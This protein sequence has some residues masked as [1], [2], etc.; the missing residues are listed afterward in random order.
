[1]PLSR[2]PRRWSVRLVLCTAPALAAAL[3]FFWLYLA[4]LAPRA[5]AHTA[6]QPSEPVGGGDGQ[7]IFTY[8][9]GLAANGVTALLR[10][11][12]SLWIGTTAGLSRYVL[13]GRGAGLTWQTFTSDDEMAADAVN[14]LWTDDVGGLWVAHPDGPI[15]LFDGTTWTTYASPTQTLEQAYE[16]IIATNAT[17]PLWAIEQ[18]GRVWTL[19]G[20]TVGY[21]VGAVWRPYGEDAGIPPGQLVAVWTGD[22]TWVASDNGQI[23]YFG[24][25]NWTTF[26]NAFD[27]VQR[28]YET[29]VASDP[30]VGPLWLVDREGGVWVRNAFNQRNP[31]PDVRRFAGGGWTS[32]S[33]GDGMA[34]GFVAE[35]RLDQYGRVWARHL[36]DETGQGGGLSLY[37][38]EGWTA[39]IPAL[40]GNVTDFWPEG[41]D[42]V[43]IGGF[44]QPEGG[45]V[46]VGGL[47]YVNL[48]TWQRF[49]LA[50]LEGAA[51]SDNWLDENDDLWLG[52][53]SAPLAPGGGGLLRYRPPQGTQPGAW[54]QVEGSLGDDVRDLWGDGQG[55]LWAAAADG[56][57][58]IALEGRKLFSYTLPVAPDQIS[59]D[60]E[61][62]VWAVA[63]G[64]GGG[65]WQWDGSAWAS[66]TVGEGLSGG[67][68]AD[69]LVSTD[70]RVYLA[71]DRGLD[72][73]D[74][75]VREP[76]SNDEW[77][78]FATLPGRH[79]RQVWQDSTGDLWLS[80]EVTPG[81]PFMLSLNQ[82]R[83]WETVLDETGSRGMGPEPLALLR[84]SQGRAWLGAP[85]GL[86]MYEPDGG[87]QWR[88]LGPVEGLPAGLVPA[89]YEDAGGT[90][91]VAV[92]DQVYR[93]DHLRLDWD[94]RRFE[95]QV[96]VVSQIAA[97]PDGSVLFVGDAGVALYRPILPDLRLDGVVN[98]ITGEVADGREPVVL[99]VGRSAMRVDLIV[100]AP[101]LSARQ[102]SYRYRLEGFDDDW[103]VLP[104]DAL[105]GKQAS[106]AY[107]GLP[108]GV[109]TFTVAARTNALDYS[110]DVGFALYVLSRP[111]E[112]SLDG[113]TIA[114]RPA[115][116][117][118]TL[119]PY[120]D[121]PIQIQLSGG[122]DQLEPLI[123]RYRIEG[124][125]DG[126]TE[127]T[128]PL[129][130]FT[131]SAADTYTFVA[132]ALD[133]E[134]QS[135]PLVGSQ[136]TVSEREE[137]ER[138][139]PLPVGS[140]AAG[141]G[142]TS[143]LLIGMA[144]W[145][146]IKRRRRESW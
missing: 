84:D 33:S 2:L 8:Q 142:V 102:L 106:I 91:W 5:L 86:F 23:G 59:G 112:L 130:S 117:P 87:A 80:S 78:I 32:F 131:L 118:G 62:N 37:D 128:Q 58:R 49:S 111:P 122:D 94:W 18:G 126:W 69:S 12:E 134:G 77:K 104:A 65:V 100:V 127:T 57:N 133:S 139:S 95:P 105:G 110:P 35:L 15:S 116:S 13:R 145:L 135:S 138:S 34:S 103:R 107:A 89:I 109:Y 44:Y 22:G 136:I 79:V 54:T 132:M 81:R 146:L 10:D 52:L 68:Y 6:D 3:L 47:T 48:N 28:Q 99:T 144:I 31:R 56:V 92:G 40:T 36:A 85:L 113:A 20:G 53:A 70:G 25:A 60:A 129:I 46:P 38:G 14:D 88:G 143:A 140:L 75:D 45:G 61:G 55:N 97:G 125:G 19:A 82:G 64:E 96:G 123:Y 120:I 90:L 41:P 121:Q 51:V 27:A 11:D 137:A 101:T 71:S 83:E 26:R 43:W 9:D 141:L 67:T 119:Q 76:Q 98:L 50:T 66:H 1:M 72:I 42:G 30:N 7:T 24:G 74:G 21:Y 124:L 17:G 63:L 16:R 108:A 115:E 114:G 4:A 39:V 73:W 29:I 93:T